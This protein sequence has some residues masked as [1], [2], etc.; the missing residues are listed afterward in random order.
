ME[1]AERQ[2]CAGG[3]LWGSPPLPGDVFPCHLA[4][5]EAP[6]SRAGGRSLLL[7]A[8]GVL[9]RWGWGLLFSMSQLLQETSPKPVAEHCHWCALCS[10]WKA[11]STRYSQGLSGC[12]WAGV[13]KW[14]GG[15]PCPPGSRVSFLLPDQWGHGISREL[16]CVLVPDPLGMRG[17]PVPGGG[18][19]AVE[20]A[21]LFSITAR[22]CAPKGV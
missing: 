16:W 5:V 15:S 22:V 10:R 6:L 3:G 21:G 4:W 20:D 2:S 18:E 1:R 9:S 17:T 7:M 19:V 8:T 12:P 13:S 11:A 14:E